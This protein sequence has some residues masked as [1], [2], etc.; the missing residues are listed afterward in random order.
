[1]ETNKYIQTTNNNFVS[2]SAVLMDP[3]QVE[4]KGRSVLHH[5]VQIDASSVRMGRYVTIAE[6]SCITAPTVPTDSSETD[7][8]VGVVVTTPIVSIGSYTFIGS[9][10][11]S[12]AAAIGSY[13]HIGHSVT[14][15]AR[16]ILKDHVVVAP[17][18]NLPADAVYPPFTYVYCCCLEDGD[19]RIQ[20]KELPPSIGV[21]VTEQATERYQDFVAS[22]SVSK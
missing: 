22:L 13:C 5:H 11:H 6:H 21:I 20:T 15:G 4:L 2:R 10:C 7:G 16:T 12:Y 1:M 3:K 19:G 9:H 14:I 8:A 18:T 17:H